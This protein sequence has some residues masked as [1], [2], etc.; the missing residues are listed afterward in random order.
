MPKVALLINPPHGGSYRSAIMRGDSLALA[1]LGQHMTELGWEPYV[2]DCFLQGWT[3]TE[4]VANI[5]GRFDAVCFTL[6][7]ESSWSSAQTILANLRK[8]CRDVPA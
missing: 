7:H 2:A 5:P 1:A 4:L 8:E 6:M 3:G